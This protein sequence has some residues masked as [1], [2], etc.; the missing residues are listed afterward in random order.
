[1][2]KQIIGWIVAGVILLLSLVLAYLWSTKDG[3]LGQN[4]SHFKSA[5]IGLDRT[6]DIYN[7][8]VATPVKSYS[9]R[10]QLEYP[11]SGTVR[12]MVG[13]KAVSIS[14]GCLVI[15]EEK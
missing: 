14:T 1:M 9:F 15:T 7:C 2:G 13:G 5:T 10:S 6:M 12:F 4:F 11:S 8:G 3:Q